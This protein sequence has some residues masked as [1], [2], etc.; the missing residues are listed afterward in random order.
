MQSLAITPTDLVSV[1]GNTVV[2][3]AINLG[4]M[5]AVSLLPIAAREICWC[6]GV[7]PHGYCGEDQ[8]QW[9]QPLLHV[10]GFL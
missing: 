9:A 5:F 7:G 4:D 10:S 8:G 3:A 1:L 6:G 2:E